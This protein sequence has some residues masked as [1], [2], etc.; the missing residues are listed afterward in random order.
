MIAR[1]FPD[2]IT[3]VVEKITDTARSLNKEIRVFNT[4][5]D[6]AE[7]G[8]VYEHPTKGSNL[9]LVQVQLGESG[10]RLTCS[11]WYKSWKGSRIVVPNLA[12]DEAMEFIKKSFLPS[13]Q[14]LYPKETQ[15]TGF[16]KDWFT[17]SKE[18]LLDLWNY[19][20]LLS[21]N[22]GLV[23]VWSLYFFLV[24]YL[25]NQR[26]YNK[27]NVLIRDPFVVAACDCQQVWEKEANNSELTE[28]LRAC[29]SKYVCLGNAKASCLLQADREWIICEF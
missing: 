21:K 1:E 28:L 23:M 3:G 5:L 24:G 4:A 6:F 29:A 22:L 8:I 26:L 14:D 20:L 16:Q 18:L 15:E 12:K 17:R 7:V 10:I 11:P 27:G 25:P 19:F 9:I 13:L 2:T